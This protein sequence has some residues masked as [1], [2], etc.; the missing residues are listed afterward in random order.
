MIMQRPSTAGQSEQEPYSFSG[1][2]LQLQGM[3][4]CFVCFAC[5]VAANLK[6]YLPVYAQESL[7]KRQEYAM[8]V[9]PSMHH[10]S[11]DKVRLAL[12]VCLVCLSD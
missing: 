11:M 9:M 6:V 7:G 12:H 1:R 3:C 5:L 8:S 4:V 2:V 10:F